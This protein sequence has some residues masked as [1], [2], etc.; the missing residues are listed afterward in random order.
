MTLLQEH[1]LRARYAGAFVQVLFRLGPLAPAR[2]VTILTNQTETAR[3][4]KRREGQL[5][6]DGVI[7]IDTASKKA[8][9]HHALPK[10][11]KKDRQNDDKQAF[12][13]P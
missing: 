2:R 8:M 4:I 12:P 9:V 5:L 7:P 6:S 10:E 3:T 11:E 1:V 13:H